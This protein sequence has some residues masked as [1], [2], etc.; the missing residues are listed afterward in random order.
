MLNLI[1][2][3]ASHKLYNY[4]TQ[5]SGYTLYTLQHRNHTCNTKIFLRTAYDIHIEEEQ[6][7]IHHDDTTIYAPVRLFDTNKEMIKAEY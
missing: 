6:L 2:E 7:Y 3:N 5:T 1:A 4:T